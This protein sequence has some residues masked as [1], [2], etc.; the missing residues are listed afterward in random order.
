MRKLCFSMLLGLILVCLSVP[1]IAASIM[2]LRWYQPEP[3]DHPWTQVGQKICDEI[4]EESNGRIKLIQYPAGALGTQQEAV[5]M[6][7]SGSLDFL[8][9]GPSILASFYE[10]VQVFSLPYLFRDREHAYKVIDSEIGQ[11]IFNDII[12]KKSGVRT[13]E[14]WYFGDR[15]LTTKD[16]PVT[17]PSDLKGVKIRCMDVPVAKNVI[18][19]LGASPTPINFSELYLALQTG[20]VQGQENPI[21]TIY[22]QKFH[23]VQGY[24][25]ETYHSVHMGTVHV[26][27]MTWKKL[28]KDDRELIMKVLKRN[29]RLIDEQIDAMT[30]IALEDMKAKGVKVI[31]PDIEAF[32]S[33]A[34]DYTMRVYG[35]D[36]G[37][38]IRKIQAVE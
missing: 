34:M 38:L 37:D 33:Y 4:F 19:A 35:K 11:E 1:G 9:S 13:I 6:L 3:P 15:T 16:I 28:P 22:S 5:D 8:T 36:W 30:E 31:T 7:R 17:K 14:F 25:I 2:E 10:P 24:I 29:R 18:A 27:E 12:L 26:S 32:R 23:E 20:V 21:T